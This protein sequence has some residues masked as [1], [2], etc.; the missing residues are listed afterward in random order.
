MNGIPAISAK[1][2]PLE[3]ENTGGKATSLIKMINGVEEVLILLFTAFGTSRDAGM[4][5]P[6]ILNVALDLLRHFFFLENNGQLAGRGSTHSLICAISIHRIQILLVIIKAHDREL[7]EIFNKVLFSK[8]IHL[9]SDPI[10]GSLN[11]AKVCDETI[12]QEQDGIRSNSVAAAFEVDELYRIDC[13]LANRVFYLA[14]EFGYDYDNVPHNIGLQQ[15]FFNLPQKVQ[16]KRFR[17][18]LLG[19]FILFS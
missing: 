18:L 17:S 1:S 14:L 4:L 12:W 19:T 9:V 3:T 11:L 5:P 7:D 15:Y 16:E 13:E 8:V 10:R 6:V 2:E